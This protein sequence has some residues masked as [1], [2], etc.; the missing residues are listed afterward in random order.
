MNDPTAIHSGR[1]LFTGAGERKYL[2]ASERRRFYEAL[3]VI[4]DVSERTFCETLFWTGCRPSEALAL[5]LM[6]VNV[7]EGLLVFRTLKKRG[8]N[9][10][11]SF[12]VVPVPRSFMT[13]FDQTHGILAAQTHKS[14]NL[15]ARLWPF[16]RQK[17][18]RLVGRVMRRARIFGIRACARGLRH[19]FGVHAILCGVPE[20]K[21]QGWMGYSD[22][23]ITAIYVNLIGPE[24][25]ATAKRMWQQEAY[26]AHRP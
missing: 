10:G 13:R 18:W 17:G 9:K 12:R 6:R 16:G 24:D 1:S 23:R 21:L 20:T 15:L 19:S 5:D 26:A 25:R 4:E 22:L 7:E 2:N 3:A 14:A 11:R 8:E